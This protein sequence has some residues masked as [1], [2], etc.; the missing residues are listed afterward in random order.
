MKMSEFMERM[1]KSIQEEE[2]LE[3][4][5]PLASFI[6][7]NGYGEIGNCVLRK[8]ELSK[9][10]EN[11]A[12][13]ICRRKFKKEEIILFDILDENEEGEEGI[14]FTETAIYQW[15]GDTVPVDEIPYDEIIK[16]DYEGDCVIL[17]LSEDE[18]VELNCGENAGEEKYTRY[19]Y[20]FIAD[21]LEFL[22]KEETEVEE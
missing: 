13:A 11:N 2:E 16:V 1:M 21:I 8:T 18:A 6:Y 22:A 14:V 5:S 20:N 12:I 9:C 10:Q 17:W 7:N 3:Q 4:R 19:M 15:C